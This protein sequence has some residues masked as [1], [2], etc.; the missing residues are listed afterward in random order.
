MRSHFTLINY[1]IKVKNTVEKE[2]MNG[3]EEKPKN[4]RK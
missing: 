4:V 3:I 2:N 1:D